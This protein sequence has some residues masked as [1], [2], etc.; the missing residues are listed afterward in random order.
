MTDTFHKK[1]SEQEKLTVFDYATEAIGWLQIVAS[2]LLGGLIGGGIVYL[3]IGNTT[4]L[5]IG[6]CL[7]AIGLVAGFVL[8]N[9]VWKNRGTINFM[10]R[11]N[12]S[13]DHDQLQPPSEQDQQHTT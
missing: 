3:W 10:S 2:P 9:K 5:L 7:A 13:A 6:V 12:A 1:D 4:G 8:A 11:V